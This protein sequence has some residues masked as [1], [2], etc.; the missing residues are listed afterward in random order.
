MD[1]TGR[2]KEVKDQAILKRLFEIEQ[3]NC[4]CYQETGRIELM[5]ANTF[6][7]NSEGGSDME[8]GRQ[9]NQEQKLVILESAKDLTHDRRPA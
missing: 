5:E 9:V 1:D 2:I 7:V 4:V 8:R 3:L 6:S